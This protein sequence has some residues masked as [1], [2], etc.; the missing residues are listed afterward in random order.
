MQSPPSAKWSR[1]A[2]R[3]RVE[4]LNKTHPNIQVKSLY[5]GQQDWQ[6]PKILA[7]VV[8]NAPP[9][10]LWYNPTIAGQLVELGGFD[11]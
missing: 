8:G 6:M 1:Q 7:S 3:S 5:V 11:L 2:K 4:L 9:D 10:M